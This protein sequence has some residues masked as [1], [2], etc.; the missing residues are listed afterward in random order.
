MMTSADVEKKLFALQKRGVKEGMRVAFL[1]SPSP[2]TVS[3]FLAL[4][5]MGAVACPINPR[6]PE[7]VQQEAAGRLSPVFFLDKEPL[8][9]CSIIHH[10]CSLAVLLFT[11]GSSGKPKIVALTLA[12]LLKSAY[13]AIQS[14]S[15]NSTDSWELALPLCHVGGIGVIARCLL[16]QAPIHW[17]HAKA[18]H[19]SLVPTQLF[20]MLREASPALFRAKAIIVGGAPISTQLL[21]ESLSKD[22][23][24]YTTWGMTET[25]SMVTLGRADLSR[26][27][28]ALLKG[29]K[30]KIR[31]D[32]QLGELFVR[33]ETLFQ[34]YLE[35]NQLRLPLTEDGWFATGDLGKIDD[36][37]NVYWQ[38]R[39]DRMFTVLGENIHPE[40]I[41]QSI[42]CLPGMIQAA[43]VPMPDEEAGNVPIAFVEFQGE[44]DE[45]T[46]RSQL[47]EKLPSFKVPQQ[48]INY[49]FFN[50]IK[51]SLE[52]LP[53]PS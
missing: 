40:E 53:R 43:V 25:A 20:R 24:L 41:E 44:F 31:G 9:Q 10:G 45:A 8:A 21:K 7:A 50:Q 35:D 36:R 33:G 19:L 47:K 14:L 46:W 15:F 52:S 48:F 34:G 5:Q 27:S 51:P 22:L 28:G 12:N 6:L 38:G 42:L 16:A 37:G 32:C 18:T 2:E 29:Q 26:H 3:T 13:G 17:N 1:A 4:W 49:A 39:K 30:M 23:P 11:S